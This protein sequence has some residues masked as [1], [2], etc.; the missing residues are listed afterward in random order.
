RCASCGLI[1]SKVGGVSD[2]LFHRTLI[3]V[4]GNHLFRERLDRTLILQET[5]CADPSVPAPL[6]DRVRDACAAWREHGEIFEK[7]R[8]RDAGGARQ[9]MRRHLST[10]VRSVQSSPVERAA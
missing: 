8:A 7:V 4:S 10:R 6:E 1:W 5:L 3:D 9:A 2:R